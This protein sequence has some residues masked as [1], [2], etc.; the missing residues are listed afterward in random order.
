MSL[1]AM[2]SAPLSPEVIEAMRPW[3]QERVGSPSSLHRSGLAARKALAL[4]REQVARFLGTSD[5][6]RVLFVSDGVEAI[7]LALKGLVESPRRRGTHVVTSAL[8]HPAVRKSVEWMKR[9]HPI[10]ESLVAP[11]CEGFLEPSA[12]QAAMREDTFVIATHAI[13]PDLGVVQNVDA[14]A[15]LSRQSGIPLFLDF[16]AAAGWQALNAEARGVGFASVSAHRFG[17]PR[18]VGVLYRDRRLRLA[19]QMEGGEQEFGLRAGAENLP[20][21]VGAGV[22][23]EMAARDREARCAR[24]RWL[25]SEFLTRLGE[26][27]SGV[28]LHGPKP[29]GAR[30]PESL[31]LSIEGVEGEAL[32]LFSDLQGLELHSGAACLSRG[33]VVPPALEAIGIEPSQARESILVSFSEALSASDLAWAVGILARGADRMRSLGPR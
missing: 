21:I 13:Q 19:P 31:N 24:V 16:D 33:A 26:L 12:V 28:R 29:G 9:R 4:A 6:E 17:G 10:Q 23:A 27:V 8:E 3:W 11:T 30:S 32:V 5:P 22:A 7:N 2:F 18:G 15:Q 14:F 20:A 1:D 25:Q